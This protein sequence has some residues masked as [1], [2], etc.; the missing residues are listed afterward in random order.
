M[1]DFKFLDKARVTAKEIIGDSRSYLSR[2]YKS[3]NNYFTAASPF[4]QILQVMAEMN[5]MLMFYVE[6]STVEQNIYTAQQPESILGLARLA[7]HDATRGFAAT[8]EIRFRWK[9][10]VTDEVAGGNLIIEPNT[11]I[12][13]DNNGLT[14]FLRTD[15]DEFLLPKSSSNWIR[16]NIIQ[17]K[18]EKQTLTSDGTSMQSFNVRTGGTT[19]HNLCKV[20]VNGEQW[21]KFNSLYEMDDNVKG[22][23]IKTGIGGGVDIY[24]GTGNFGII[25]PNGATIEIEYIKCNGLE[26]NLNQAGDL[27]FKWLGEGKD[28][29]GET[30]DLNELLDTETT[31]APFMGANPETPE[32]TRLMA[33]LASKSF[34]LANPDAYEYFLTRYAQFSYL[35]AYNTTDDGYL[36]DDNVIYIFAIPDIEKRLLTGTDY[37]SVNEDEF[38]FNKEET[39][40]MLGVIEDSGQQMVTS[41]AV[42]VQPKAVKYRMDISIR[43]FEGFK[44]EDIFNDVRAAI[45]NY[46]VNVIR[47]DKLP[48]SDIIALI[49]GVEGVD[50]VNIQFVSSIEEQARKDGY[51]T[52]DQVTVVPSTPELE[53]VDGEQKRLV[54]FKRII[55]TKK[56]ILENPNMLVPVTGEKETQDWY[57]TIGLDKYGDIILDK[58]EVA[59]FRG[60]W[61]DRDGELVKDEPAIGE[62]ASLSV[63]FDNPPV[64]NTIYSRVQAGNRRAY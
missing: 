59:V 62:M 58:E 25:P 20:S 24:F 48:K 6:D 22:Y 19:D 10:G 17:G 2:V 32:F 8:G 14:Y 50:A 11:E 23:L 21:Q 13:Y 30:H 43:W 40:R 61:E 4:S 26:G 53:G 47:R 37:F 45:S 54:F 33:P 35:D 16:A 12:V 28:S 5:E 49:E 64:P 44:Q 34:V 15:K 41:E 31:T 51:Y 1:A 46:L 36:D 63:Y 52:Y 27:T 18:L 38:F 57:N 9:P 3:A 42:F 55:E 56:I 60:G 29:T 7:G 39:D